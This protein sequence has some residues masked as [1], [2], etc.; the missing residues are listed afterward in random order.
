MNA[1]ATR[2]YFLS[3]PEAILDY[4]FGPDVEVY[5][6]KGKM[7][8]TLGWEQELARINLKCD[9]EQALMLR[10]VFDAVV[11]GYHMNKAHWN[12]VLLDGSLPAGELQRMIDHS[13]GLV[14][15][16]MPKADRTSLE[17]EYGKEHLY[18][19]L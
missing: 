13:Y 16:K 12:T 15:R 19:A 3:K 6:V 2:N 10:D 7:F 4:P 11:P 17:V 8:G 9:P 18:N 5:K 1:D 14:V